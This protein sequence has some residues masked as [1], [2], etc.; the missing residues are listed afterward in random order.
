MVFMYRMLLLG[1]AMSTLLGILILNQKERVV[2]V[3]RCLSSP[4]YE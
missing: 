2:V 1:K 3:G 4:V